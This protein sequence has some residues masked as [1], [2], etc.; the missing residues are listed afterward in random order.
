MFSSE[1]V[2]FG[3]GGWVHLQVRFSMINKVATTHCSFLR[4]QIKREDIST[5]AVSVTKTEAYRILRDV[6]IVSRGVCI[7]SNR[8]T[9]IDSK[10]SEMEILAQPLSS[11]F[12]IEN[13]TSKKAW[14]G[15]EWGVASWPPMILGT[16]LSMGMM[17][18][19]YKLRKFS[20]VV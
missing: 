4:L 3:D 20:L 7:V 15:M 17:G 11:P 12:I 13:L 1:E 18:C 6:C 5:N 14:N 16:V 2:V 9:C 10:L 8:L 19:L